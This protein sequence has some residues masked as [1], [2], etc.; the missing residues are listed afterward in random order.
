MLFCEAALLLCLK[1]LFCSSND[2][3]NKVMNSINI[4]EVS[5]VDKNKTLIITKQFFYEDSEHS[6]CI[7]KNTT[8][9]KEFEEM[10]ESQSI[11]DYSVHTKPRF[12]VF[13]YMQEEDIQTLDDYKNDQEK[14][15]VDLYKTSITTKQKRESNLQF[16]KI[17]TK[18]KYDLLT[19]SNSK[20]MYTALDFH[21]GCF[22][23]NGSTKNIGN[24]E[25]KEQSLQTDSDPTNN[26]QCPYVSTHTS[27]INTIEIKKQPFEAEKIQIKKARYCFNA[28][29][30]YADSNEPLYH[31]DRFS[32]DLNLNQNQIINREYRDDCCYKNT[33]VKN[34]D[35]LSYNCMYEQSFKR[36]HYLSQELQLKTIPNNIGFLQN[37]N[38]EHGYKIEKNIC[39]VEKQSTLENNTHNEINFELNREKYIQVNAS[40]PKIIFKL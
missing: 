23:V 27:K 38:C 21:C 7:N 5:D 24:S 14:Y 8:K 30:S 37:S 13:K 19:D 4:K 10:Q 39:N 32:Y 29:R 12:S 11:T 16:K 2:D 17:S 31:T 22:D 15:S 6:N 1:G 18:Y 33:Q 9:V 3:H 36:S 34:Q 40:D 35:N 25:N 28:A 26:Y 20:T